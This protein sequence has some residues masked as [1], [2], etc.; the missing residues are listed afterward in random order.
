MLKRYILSF[1][2]K[3]N[4]ISKEKFLK[5]I[6][7]QD[8]DYNLLRKSELFDCKWYLDHYPD[9][10]AAKIDPI[11]HFLN[12][13]WR[14]NRNPSSLFITKF[15]LQYNPD[16]KKAQINP[17][18]HYIRHGKKEGRNIGYSLSEYK[19][20]KKS[21]YF[22]KRWY[23]DQYKDVFE[24]NMDPI[25]HYM[26]IGWKLGYNPSYKFNTN[27]YLDSYPDIKEAK[28]CPLL[29][30]IQDGY[31]EGRVISNCSC[32][33]TVVI[34]NF[35]VFT[36]IVRQIYRCIYKR[37]IQVNKHV[38]IAVHVYLFYEDLWFEIKNYLKNLECYQYDLFISSPSE[39]SERISNDIYSFKKKTRI[40]VTEN[41]GFDL[42]PFIYF[43]H[44]INLRRY[45][46][47]FK[48]HTKRNITPG[49]YYGVY[50]KGND[51]RTLLY[52]GIL[53]V[54]TV[55]KVI[56]D[57]TGNNSIGL[58]SHK[59]LIF[60]K[61]DIYNKEET[62]R[63][64]RSFN[65][66]VPEKYVFVAGT[67][68]AGRAELFQ[69]IKDKVKF[70]DF[71]ISKRGEFTVA[72]SF[73]RILSLNIL[74]QGFTI[75][76]YHTFR[77]NTFMR[78]IQASIHPYKPLC[79][80]NH[81][82][83][84][85]YHFYKITNKVEGKRFI[86]SSL[87]KEKD[88]KLYEALVKKA[89]IDLQVDNQIPKES[90]DYH[91]ALKE[92]VADRIVAKIVSPQEIT[93]FKLIGNAISV[94]KESKQKGINILR[95]CSQ[96]PQFIIQGKYLLE[97][98]ES[99]LFS[100]NIKKIIQK[101][102]PYCTC[103][104]DQF[105]TINNGKLSPESW[106]AIP[107]NTIINENGKYC[108][109]DCNI[110]YLAGVPK[111]YFIYRVVNDLIYYS[112]EKNVVYSKSEAV[113][114]YSNLCTE[115]GICGNFKLDQQL[116]KNLQ[117][118]LFGKVGKKQI[119]MDLIRLISFHISLVRRIYHR[120]GKLRIIDENYE[121]VSKSKYFNEK[122]YV[123]KY[124]EVIDSNL[125]PLYYWLSKGWKKNQDPCKTFSVDYYL[126]RYPDI[127]VAKVNPLIHYIEHGKREGRLC[128]LNNDYCAI[129]KSKFF[130][131]E[132]Y[133]ST[134]NVPKRV[135][136]YMHYLTKGYLTG[137]N[138][139]PLFDTKKY[140]AVYPDVLKSRMNPLAHWELKGK[141]EI[142]RTY[143]TPNSKPEYILPKDYKTAISKKK[144]LLVSHILNHTG[145]PILLIQVAK[146]FK[147]MGFEV[148]VMSPKKGDLIEEFLKEDVPVIIDENC[149]VPNFDIEL[150]CKFDFCICN[151]ILL[152]ASYSI[153]SRKIPTLWWIH[154]NVLPVQVHDLMRDALR[155]A[156]NVYV[157]G[158]LTK[159]YISPY[160]KNVKIL[161]YPIN[162]EV[163]IVKKDF[164][165][166]RLLKISVYATL[167]ERKGQDI[168]V[169]AIKL[170]P[171]KIRSQCIFE[172][173]GEEAQP[174]FKKNV[175]D[176]IASGINEIKY[177]KL[178]KNRK[179]YHS[180]LDNVDILCCPS[181][182]DPYPLVVIDALMHGCPVILS[183]HVG[184]KD[185]IEEME[186]GVVFESKNAEH[187][188]KCL[189]KIIEHKDNLPSMSKRARETF[190]ENFDYLE[191][192]KKF[193]AIMEEICKK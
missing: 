23:L 25:I 185:I 9:I 6:K 118:Y 155:K 158:N 42:G 173:V 160:N 153:F 18:L 109:F 53:G 189:R 74:S 104:F 183:D 119:I 108:F 68:F 45:D 64:M 107:H 174:G 130:D 36:S 161:P 26:L 164:K 180:S 19:S 192:S 115:L 4:L 100:K 131:K 72:H 86:I 105:K 123:K 106:D 89:K 60:K 52:E 46:I 172:L 171:K 8:S 96:E 14:E 121:L 128:N 43:L 138:P 148:V 49:N 182:E 157:P 93:K 91:F 50:M 32:V 186:N 190:L 84:K 28:L 44:K 85:N 10:K 65:I 17:L 29:H 66:T 48:I 113:K 92:L 39:L 126:K 102:I 146:M 67:M 56:N 5:K 136:A 188:A 82:M 73:E 62:I 134:Y 31:K 140:L 7:D 63:T 169:R 27:F 120:K 116:E 122:W 110:K 2:H 111:S 147:T 59:R 156:K 58:I 76:G 38:K 103:V 35:G 34:K 114:L 143:F 83:I 163:K 95:V 175:L 90:F 117:L 61:D 125:D 193:A 178:I 133:C 179:L 1:V 132:W 176:P 152:W 170:L 151:T 99:L 70:E 135:D 15:Y 40:I 150:P 30:Y 71:P 177:V 166:D 20:I 11:L 33:D 149:I 187:L 54:R 16:I 181:R 69:N 55:H 81:E 78:F 24:Q 12:H 141:Y 154:D 167:H 22:D 127:K 75:K 165:N 51:W 3:L 129:K 162:D 124:P 88:P 79:F 101:L 191:C 145:A 97:T 41:R 94:E 112:A 37:S 142:T 98:L 77:W 57:L 87:L 168:F 137:N 13:G 80:Y 139:S 21:G 47:I 184:E 144:I 159:S